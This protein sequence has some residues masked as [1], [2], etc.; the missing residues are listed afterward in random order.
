[1]LFLLEDA[2]KENLLASRLERFKAAAIDNLIIYVPA[3][4]LVSVFPKK[5]DIPSIAAAALGL[6]LLVVVLVQGGLLV[7]RGQTIGKKLVNIQIVRSKD[8]QNGG[9]VSNVLLRAIVNS[10]ITLIPL[11]LLIDVLFIFSDTKRCLHDRLAGTIVVKN[12]AGQE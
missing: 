5:E 8:G 11:Y 4:I 12:F 9:F 3:V 1:M 10:I 7:A 2:I 6:Y